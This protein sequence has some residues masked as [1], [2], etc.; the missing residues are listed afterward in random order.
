MG[1][2]GPA[3]RAAFAGSEVPRERRQIPPG[4]LCRRFRCDRLAQVQW[5]PV[6][7]AGLLLLFAIRLGCLSF[8]LQFRFGE[9]RE[10]AMRQ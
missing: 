5:S 4:C 3:T 10:I 9:N 2:A 7:R 6:Q 1:T 8:R